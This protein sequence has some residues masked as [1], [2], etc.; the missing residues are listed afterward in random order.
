MRVKEREIERDGESKKAST[1]YFKY[2]CTLMCKK[3][4]SFRYKVKLKF[5]FNYERIKRI[6]RA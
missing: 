4:L 5:G 2:K 6:E 3:K 1:L